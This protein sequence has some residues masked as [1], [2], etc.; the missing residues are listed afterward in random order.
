MMSIH[1]K[2]AAVVVVLVTMF[3]VVRIARPLMTAAGSGGLGAVSFG[4]AEALVVFVVPAVCI[5][6]LVYWLSKRS[7]RRPTARR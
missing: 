5:G 3:T 6:V 1:A 7:S 4:P 2:R